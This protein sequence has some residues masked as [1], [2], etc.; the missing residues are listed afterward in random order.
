MSPP[1]TVR[2]AARVP[3]LA[4]KDPAML[5]YLADFKAQA[6]AATASVNPASLLW[7]PVSNAIPEPASLSGLHT[8]QQAS[9]RAIDT[10]EE[11]LVHAAA[12]LSDAV[13]RARWGGAMPVAAKAQMLA[14]SP[15]TTP[16]MHGGGAHTPL[17]CPSPLATVAVTTVSAGGGGAG[18]VSAA[19]DVI[20]T[21][22]T[23]T[24]GPIPAP[25]LAAPQASPPAAAVASAASV[26]SSTLP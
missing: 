20:L 24:L 6:A 5:A 26:S 22:G 16:S 10:A 13:A 17:P 12:A 11:G 1:P 4:S 9:A 15:A 23:T 19:F 7:S 8:A 25:S 14:L 2:P 21:A 18:T 3:A